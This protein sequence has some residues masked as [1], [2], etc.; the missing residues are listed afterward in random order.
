MRTRK[1]RQSARTQRGDTDGKPSEGSEAG[2][3]APSS[4]PDRGSTPHPSTTNKNKNDM[5]DKDRDL[6]AAARALHYTEW[7]ICGQ[8]AAECDTD[9]ARGI[10]NGIASD[11]NHAEEYHSRLL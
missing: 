8:Y 11:L 9:E 7:G 2:A 6:I 3:R 4:R 10:I 5:T 1:P